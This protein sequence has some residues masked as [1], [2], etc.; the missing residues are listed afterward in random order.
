MIENFLE[1]IGA[2]VKP[3]AKRFVEE[4]FTYDSPRK[5]KVIYILVFALLFS[6][7]VGIIYW[8]FS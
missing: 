4:Q 1:V 3:S 7:A 5:K 8:I 2:F 6:L